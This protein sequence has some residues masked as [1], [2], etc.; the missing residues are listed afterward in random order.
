LAETLT[1]HPPGKE[2]VV[3]AWPTSWEGYAHAFLYAM[4][5]VTHYPEFGMML[6]LALSVVAIIA[7]TRA[8]R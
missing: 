3:R 2:I 8:S 1:L 4:L 5:G 6:Y 7:T